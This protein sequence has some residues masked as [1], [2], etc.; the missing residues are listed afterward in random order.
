M[1]HAEEHLR[2]GTPILARGKMRRK[3]PELERALAGHFGPH[4]R[5]LVARQLAHL[6]DLDEL[7]AEVSA[8]IARRLA[9]LC[10]ENVTKL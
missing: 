10:G 5:F 2:R 6:D 7:I 3:I 9:P 4:Q 1:D 8:Q